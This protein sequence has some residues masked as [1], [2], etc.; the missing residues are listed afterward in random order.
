MNQYFIYL[1]TAVAFLEVIGDILFKE[2]SIH[3]KN[4]MLVLGILAYTAATLFW[5]FSLKYQSLSKAMVIFAVLTL[6]VGILVGVFFYKEELSALNI[7]GI[8]IGLTSIIFL[9]M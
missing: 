7:V 9:E 3:N 4:Y 1:V 5:A 6:I 8:V 2:W